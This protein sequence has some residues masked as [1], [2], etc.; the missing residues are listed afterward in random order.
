[1]FQILIITT[2]NKI[3]DLQTG[4]A[5]EYLV[6]ADLIIKGC[7]AFPSE[8]GLPYDIVAD[9]DNKLYKIQVK[10]RSTNNKT[11]IRNDSVPIYQFCIGA[12]GKKGKRKIYD[13]S[14]VDM[15]ALVIL[16]TKMIAYIPYFNTKSTMN[17]RI[18]AFKGQYHDEQGD[19][20]KSKVMKLKS[21]GHDNKYISKQLGIS[22]KMTQIYV[23]DSPIK[24]KGTFSGVYFDEF[25]LEKCLSEVCK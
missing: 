17:F 22:R 9:I 11:P 18:P 6:C 12:N 20:I 19:I 21:E 16:D 2:M 25:S 8:Q 7:I 5:G 14:K 3:S 1:M 24:R 15:F 23:R 4:K 10:T 13:I